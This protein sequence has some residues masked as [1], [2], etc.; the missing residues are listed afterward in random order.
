MRG[1]LAALTLAVTAAVSLRVGDRQQTAQDLAVA[2]PLARE[3]ND[4]PIVALVGVGTAGLAM[5]MGRTRD[6]AYMLGAAARLRGGDDFTEPTVAYLIGAVEPE[7]GGSFNES[8]G[9]GKLLSI[10]AALKLLDPA[11]LVAASGR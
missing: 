6:A 7:L 4:M 5:L 11:G 9:E 2:F 1:H 10:D 3:T 8:Y